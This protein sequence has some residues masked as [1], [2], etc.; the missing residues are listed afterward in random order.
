MS[1]S[2]EWGDE[3][4]TIV[5]WDFRGSWTWREFTVAQDQ[6]TRMLATVDHTVAVI[7][8]M[9]NSP[10]L[11]ANALAL[12][13]SYLQRAAGNTGLIVVVGASRLVKTMIAVF[14][15]INPRKDIPGTDFTFAN[16]IKEAY[17]FIAENGHGKPC[18]GAV[19]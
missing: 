13:L 16:T 8:D 4:H 11:P 2:I 1:I 15:R 6:A 12:Y 10:V 7:A 14:L 9:K 3:D 5:Y 17:L 18:A 19:S